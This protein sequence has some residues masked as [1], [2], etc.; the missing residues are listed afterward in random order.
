MGQAFPPPQRLNENNDSAAQFTCLPDE[1]GVR[2][3]VEE[4]ARLRELVAR[5]SKLV[6]MHIVEERD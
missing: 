2:A 3:L 4:N 6:L 1:A 5:L